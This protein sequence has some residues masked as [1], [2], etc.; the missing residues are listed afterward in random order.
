MHQIG[1]S[2][3]D[4]IFYFWDEATKRLAETPGSQGSKTQDLHLGSIKPALHGRFSAAL[5]DGKKVSL[6]PLLDVLGD[7]LQ[8]YTPEKAAKITGIHADVIRQVALP[9][10][11]VDVKVC[12]VDETWSGLKLVLRKDRRR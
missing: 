1:V 7:H 3:T 4:E 8:Q 10:G 5:A 11:L 6:R 12:A 2:E 9:M